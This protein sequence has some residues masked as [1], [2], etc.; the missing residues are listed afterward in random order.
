MAVLVIFSGV[1][2]VALY[3]RV[4]RYLIHRA[5]R[6]IAGAE[7]TD[8][9]K[10]EALKRFVAVGDRYPEV[11]RRLGDETNRQ[12]PTKRPAQHQIGSLCLA[13]RP[14]G[15]VAGIGTALPNE[16]QQWLLLP[17]NWWDN[18]RFNTGTE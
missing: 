15:V 10:I 13:I 9:E 8:Q 2:V 12:F 11:A 7:M 3:P 4:Q 6:Q 5:I 18:D 1:S 17:E 14:D 16:G